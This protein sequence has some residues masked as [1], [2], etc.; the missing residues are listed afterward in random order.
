MSSSADYWAGTNCV[1]HGLVSRFI[2]E[3]MISIAAVC[4][5]D[6]I[7]SSSPSSGS[8]PFLL[9]LLG[10]KDMVLYMLFIF[11]LKAKNLLVLVGKICTIA[12][13]NFFLF[14]VCLDD[15][16]SLVLILVGN[17]NLEIHLF[18]IW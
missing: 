1:G 15:F 17:T 16:I 11:F 5:H 18:Q 10:H 6:S 2:T 14:L 8:C 9:C 3:C 4:L 13:I 12:S 7:H